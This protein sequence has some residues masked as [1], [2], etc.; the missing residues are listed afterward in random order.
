[1]TTSLLAATSVTVNASAA[2]TAWLNAF[3]ATGDDKGRRVL[4][5]TLAIE[6][7]R[8]GVQFVASDA[9]LL[10]RTWVPA[11]DTDAEWPGDYARPLRA[12][13][14]MDVDHFAQAFI[15]TLLSASKELD[16]A[17]LSL[18]IEEAPEHDG[19]TPLGAEFS[20]EVLTLRAFG[21]QLHC[22]LYEDLYVNWRRLRFGIDEGERVDG[23]KLAT[24]MFATVGKLRGIHA[25]ECTFT[26]D[27]RKIIL[28]GDRSF[29]GLLM[30]M[31]RSKKETP[32]PTPHAEQT[33]A[34]EH[35]NTSGRDRAAGN[36]A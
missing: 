16:T 2:A 24:H 35:T 30:P 25:I 3:L 33:D 28:T 31:T 1:M 19:E 18:T 29:K 10:F 20:A 17:E 27:E 9:T 6:M 34:L 13:V 21:Q 14:V 36:D 4:Y 15:R 32:K 11:H 23:M 7:Y 22:R 26:G 12:V 8:D 5:R